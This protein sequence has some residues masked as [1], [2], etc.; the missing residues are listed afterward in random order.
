MKINIQADSRKLGIEA[1]KRA[2]F[3]IRK[4]IELN[5]CANIILATGSSQFAT[6]KQLIN[7]DGIAW[8]KVS[9]YHLDE[10]INLSI[11]HIASFRKYLMERFISK[12]PKAKAVYLI[13]GEIDPE[14]ECR[15]LEK[16]IRKTTIDLA[17]IGI[18][19]NG[20]I[21]FNDPPADFQT[22]K[23][24]IVVDLNKECRE[25][26]INEGW[27]ESFSEVPGQAISMSVKQIMLSKNIICSVP[28]KRKAIAVKNTL[29]QK[30]SNWYPATILQ[31]HPHCY[32]YLEASSAAKL[33][34]G[35]YIS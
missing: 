18:G 21:A 12:I 7:E 8:D 32:L 34:E 23:A 15:R 10:Y 9:I 24:Y 19:E 13:N 1:G 28:D 16:L 11:T 6:L 5:D 31:N 35:T 17:L 14:E 29:E 4:A 2:A 25:Q 3:F 26:Q 20:H 22:D 33:K 27:F 30:V